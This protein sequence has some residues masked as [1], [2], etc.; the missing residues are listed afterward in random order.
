[1]FFLFWNGY[2]AKK[3]K[4]SIIK[5]AENFIRELPKNK[6]NPT[7][8]TPDGEGGITLKWRLQS[9]VTILNFEVGLVHLVKEL[10]NGEIISQEGVIYLSSDFIP[11]EILEHIPNQSLPN[12]H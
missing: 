7:E 6:M 11:S 10:N 8:I 4:E 2:Y 9:E 1:M 12:V 5:V 3:T